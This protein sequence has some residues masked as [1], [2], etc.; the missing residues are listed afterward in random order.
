MLFK[1]MKE[2]KE[3]KLIEIIKCGLGWLEII[4]EDMDYDVLISVYPSIKRYNSERNQKTID[5][6]PNVAYNKSKEA[7]FD[8]R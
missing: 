8:R 4:G 6:V 5:N 3:I 2:L 7:L 1:C